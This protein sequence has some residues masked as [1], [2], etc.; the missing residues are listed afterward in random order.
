MQQVNRARQKRPWRCGAFLTPVVSARPGRV[1]WPAWA[2]AFPPVTSFEGVNTHVEGAGDLA[3][4]TGTY[5]MRLTPPGATAEVEDRGRY[6]SIWKR[7]ADGSWKIVQERGCRCRQKPSQA[8]SL[9]QLY[10]AATR[11]VG[12]IVSLFQGACP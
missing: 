5:T 7:Q 12:V 6:I 3:Y 1:V 2:T 11:R 8:G 9:A 4:A 10:G